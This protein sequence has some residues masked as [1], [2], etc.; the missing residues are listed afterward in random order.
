MM[1]NEKKIKNEKTILKKHEKNSWTIAIF[2]VLENL[3]F[4]RVFFIC[5][6]FFSNSFCY[7]FF[8]TFLL[9]V[10]ELMNNDKK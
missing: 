10:V 6:S 8:L 4:P 3:K 7:L 2:H 1:K 5:L 9:P